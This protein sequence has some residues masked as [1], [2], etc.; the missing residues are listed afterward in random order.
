MALWSCETFQLLS[1]VA[2]SGW[3]H[4]VA[5]SPLAAGQL[6]A[7]GSSGVHFCVIHA[8]GSDVALKV[9]V[10]SGTFQ[11]NFIYRPLQ[12]QPQLTQ[13]AVNNN[14]KTFFKKTIK[15]IKL[16]SHAGSKAKE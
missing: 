9:R 5:F 15:E 1:S 10:N 6:A 2:V 3:V 13:S 4:D 14:I 7:V 8:Q 11:L 16:L 12:E